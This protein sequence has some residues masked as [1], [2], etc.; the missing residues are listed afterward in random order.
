MPRS[1]ADRLP[2]AAAPEPETKT[3]A[4]LAR[5][6]IYEDI[7]SGALK[8]GEKLQPDMLKERYGLGLSPIREALIRLS[9]E[10]IVSVEG[11]RGFAVPPTSQAEVRDI[12]RVRFELSAFAL[13][14]SIRLGDDDWEAAVVAAFHRLERIAEAMRKNPR[15]YLDEWETRNL[16]FHAALESGCGSPLTLRLIA[17]VYGLSERYRRQFVDYRDLLPAAQDEHRQIMEATLA[18]D[19]PR[20]IKALEHHIMGNMQ[21]VAVRV[22][23]KPGAERGVRGSSAHGTP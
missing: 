13:G 1:T 2:A 5:H 8:S 21:K 9:V 20:A 19:A 12:A 4:E 15:Q 23:R 3:I 17:Q 16:A 11:Q 18:R 10:G 22:E 7:V 6:R 14:E